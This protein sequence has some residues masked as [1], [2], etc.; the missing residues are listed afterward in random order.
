M[1]QEIPVFEENIYAFKATGKLT[2]EDYRQFLPR[3]TE[4]VEKYGPLSLFIELED[5]QGWEPKAAWADMKFGLEHAEDFERIAI[6]GEKRWLKWMTALGNLF[7]PTEIRYFTRDELQQAWDWLRKADEKEEKQSPATETAETS[8]VII[9]PYAHIL[10]AIDFTRHSDAALRRAV[11]LARH[12]NAKLSLIHAMEQM[13]YQ[14]ADVETVIIP[15]NF[16]AEERALFEQ[17]E[18]RLSDMAKKLDLPCVQHKV[19]WGS[20][21]STVLSYAEA[22]NA[23]LI[24]TG[25]HGRHG[26]A[27][28]MGST[29]SGIMHGARC[30]VLVVKLQ[31]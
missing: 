23:D 27:R 5:F 9:K 18:A 1:F 15:N 19:L 12:H 17:A 2:D 26:L 16:F 25:S 6:V 7:T 22:Q 4:V 3:L 8:P 24:V 10:V 20:P 11:E 30:D 13:I 21:K 31:G 14:Y 29:A 28:L